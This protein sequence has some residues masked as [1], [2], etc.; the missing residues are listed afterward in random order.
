MGIDENKMMACLWLS[1]MNR[2]C[3]V[4][5]SM[6]SR[7]LKKI[8]SLEAFLAIKPDILIEQM[9]LSPEKTLRLKS[10]LH[11]REARQE[12]ARKAEDAVKQKISAVCCQD[13]DYPAR[14]S[15]INGSPFV[16][17]FRG[18]RYHEIMASPYFVTVIGTRAP[19]AYGRMAVDDIAAGLA[20]RGIVVVSGLA[21]GIDTAAHQAALQKKG[22]TVAVVGCG[23][24]VPYPTENRK[25]M[26]D[27][28]EQ[29]L[30]ISEHPPGTVPLKQYFPARNRIL[31]GLS[32]A[33]A[34]I[35]ASKKSGTMITASFAGDQGRDVFA[36]PGSIFSPFSSGCNQLI[37]EGA[38]V[39][40]GVED[41][42]W[43]MPAGLFQ[44]SLEQSIRRLND[45]GDPVSENQPVTEEDRLLCMLL[46]GHPLQLAE[47]AAVSGLDF[48]SAAAR[49]TKMEIDDL[50]IC[51]RGRY[52]LTRKALSSI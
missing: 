15:T 16:L 47:F 24:D 12:L 40:C 4:T 6:I 2:K 41:I 35:E 20:E 1:E 28:A 32:D 25:L 52:T 34:V 31:S 44:M 23:P 13:T 21:R 19:T 38:E 46:A 48:A 18:S 8:G 10:F 45:T 50:V 39:L 11:D 17:Y 43:R 29:G 3:G 51:E 27:I 37:R 49:L 36:V 7:M 9:A 26:E 14:L 22:L 5:G 42:L 30:V 33:V